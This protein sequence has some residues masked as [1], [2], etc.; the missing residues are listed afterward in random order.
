MFSTAYTLTR[1]AEHRQSA[2]SRTYGAT[3]TSDDETWPDATHIWS[4]TV[5]VATSGYGPAGS[6][7]V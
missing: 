3:G 4:W 6:S 7:F 2:P 5:S 1:T